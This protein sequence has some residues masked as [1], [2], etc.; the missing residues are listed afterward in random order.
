MFRLICWSHVNHLGSFWY[1]TN[2]QVLN[3]GLLLNYLL[4][5]LSFTRCLVWL[6]HLLGAKL[7][8]CRSYYIDVVSCSTHAWILKK[9]NWY[10]HQGWDFTSPQLSQKFKKFIPFFCW[11]HQT[12]ACGVSRWDSIKNHQMMQDVSLW[13]GILSAHDGTMFCGT[14]EVAVLHP[15]NG[16]PSQSVQLRLFIALILS[17]QQNSSG[18]HLFEWGWYV[19][20]VRG[21]Y[22]VPNKYSVEM[23]SAWVSAGVE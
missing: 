2:L 5:S 20:H 19:S 6:A 10:Q 11:M 22:L 16:C 14:M 4:A 9:Q 12:M 18:C 13:V 23:D 3:Y 17:I 7:M 21:G 1:V 15:N 8:K